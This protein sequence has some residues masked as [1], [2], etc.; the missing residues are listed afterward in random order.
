MMMSAFSFIFC[1]KS[2]PTLKFEFESKWFEK[3]Q[4]FLKKK[5]LFFFPQGG[6]AE[7]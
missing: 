2:R 3:I 1:G 7:T 6:W 4:R 5:I